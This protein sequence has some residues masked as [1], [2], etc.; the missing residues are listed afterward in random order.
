MKKQSIYEILLEN[1][2]ADGRLPQS[3]S[4]PCGEKPLNELRFMPGARD[5]IGIFHTNTGSPDEAAEEMVRLLKEIWNVRKPTPV[6][7]LFSGK[8][9]LNHAKDRIDAL[10]REHGTLA[11][12]DPVLDAIRKNHSGVDIHSMIQYA[13]GQAFESSEAEFVKLGIALLGLLDLTNSEEIVDKLLVLA[14]YEEFTL[15]AAVA[16]LNCENS[17]KL[18]FEMA[19]KVSGWGK[20]HVVQRLQADTDEIKDWILRRGC[21]NSIMDAYLGLE[22]ADKGDLIA[23]LRRGGLDEELFEGVSIIINALLDEGPVSGISE[24]EHARGALLLYL[25]IAEHNAVT[26]KHLWYVLN[27]QSWLEHSEAADKE[28]LQRICETIISRENWQDVIQTIMAEP[29]DDQFFFAVN[30]AGRLGMDISAQLFAAVKSSPLKHY[31]Y[32]SQLYGNPEYAK[33]LTALYET[34]LPLDQMEKGMG[35]YLF[36]PAYTQ[37][38]HC[39]NF[40]LQELAGYPGMGEGLICNALASP[41]TWLRHGAMKAMEEW[42][43]ITGTGLDEISEALY[44]MVNTVLPTEIKSD[45]KE[46]ME[47]LVKASQ[48]SQ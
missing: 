12:I 47:K 3:F 34:T 27:V 29:E 11:V 16:L 23:V 7:K 6:T 38:H 46:R 35:D 45:Y 19:Q 37:E 44:T 4:L 33:E 31:G 41:V 24:Y 20:I 21:E 39:L 30:T 18:L 25:Q 28:E 26:I 43:Q 10:V 40:I 48:K 15:F 8:H 32:I 36:A 2:T 1:R 17:N 13:A 5:G 22:C 42:C 14:L 9:H